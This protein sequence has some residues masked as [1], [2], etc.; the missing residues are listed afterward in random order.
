MSAAFVGRVFLLALILLPLSARAELDQ[1]NPWA[2]QVPPIQVPSHPIGQNGPLPEYESAQTFTVGLDGPLS[3]V[4]V[5]V[6][7]LED[8][9]GLIVEIRPT[10][11]GVPSADPSSVLASAAIP[12]WL[13]RFNW[14]GGYWVDA[15]F[16]ED[17]PEVTAGQQ[18]AIVIRS[19][20]PGY[21]LAFGHIH[22]LYTGGNSF[23]RQGPT[24]TWVQ[25]C[26]SGS[27][28][29]TNPQ[30]RD[31]VFFKTFVGS[32]THAP[33]LPPVPAL[34]PIALGVV[35]VLLA[36]TAAVLGRLSSRS[37]SA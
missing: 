18:L 9:A 4:R 24:G 29:C 14:D 12:Y 15:N 36:A 6:G 13:V 28:G 32:V 19:L 10:I 17:A 3:E 25:V 23:K 20:T 1:Y 35:A 33:T 26:A 22:D 34:S 11:A 7:R 37:R 2:P 30:N 5:W 8:G 31:D 27:G 21:Y 16:G